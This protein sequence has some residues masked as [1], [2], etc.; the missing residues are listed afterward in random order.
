MKIKILFLLVIFLCTTFSL[1]QVDIFV[2]D[3]GIKP[4]DFIYIN[5]NGKKDSIPYYVL[6]DSLGPIMM[7]D[8]CLHGD[9]I[10][11][12]EAC[13]NILKYI[14]ITKGKL[15]VIPK[16]NLPAFNKK[17]RSYDNDKR[18]LNRL[19]PGKKCKDTT[20]YECKLSS[21]FMEIVDKLKPNLVLNLHECMRY[22]TSREDKIFKVDANYG[23]TIIACPTNSQV[24]R[25]I[26][27]LNVIKNDINRELSYGYYNFNNIY[28]KNKPE[29]GYSL[30]YI[31]YKYPDVLS[32]TIETYR[33]NNYKDQDFKI[34]YTTQV[35]DPQFEGGQRFGSGFDLEDR[36]ILQ[37]IC[38]FKFLKFMKI[39]FNYADFKT[40]EDALESIKPKISKPGDLNKKTN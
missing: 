26:N 17:Q 12:Y 16:V 18:D 37:I 31:V 35:D 14:H 29:S 39:E 25:D 38:I 5:D 40:I 13:L 22:N 4:F 33:N 20:W 30:D 32:Y 2:K 9:E 19:F 36:V 15:I 27:N 10:A 34:E 28:Y 23:N 24:E 8:A 21:D 11:G 7:I 3:I 6:G 1:S